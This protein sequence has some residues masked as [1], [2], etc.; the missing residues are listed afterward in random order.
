MTTIIAVLKDNGQVI[1]GHDS[2][3]SLTQDGYS[4]RWSVVVDKW[5]VRD[6]IAIALSGESQQLDRLAAYLK[7]NTQE[8]SALIRSVTAL[9]EEDTS[10]P[11]LLAVTA[12]QLYYIADASARA[13]VQMRNTYYTTGSGA[14]LAMGALCA[15]AKTKGSLEEADV[16]MALE[17]AATY[18]LYTTGPFVVKTQTLSR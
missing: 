10:K 16:L 11:D 2:C 17:V 13:V 6:N 7:G 4:T 15:L 5:A 18:D 12:G 1:L 14:D 8:P 3:V 9:F